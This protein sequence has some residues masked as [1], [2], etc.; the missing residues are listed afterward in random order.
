[1]KMTR[2]FFYSLLLTIVSFVYADDAKIPAIA[3]PQ[4]AAQLVATETASSEENAEAAIETQ[5]MTEAAKRGERLHKAKCMGC[6]MILANSDPA[7]LQYLRDNRKIKSDSG[8]KT[9]VVRCVKA[10][11]FQWDEDKEIADIIA[12]L[13]EKFYQFETQTSK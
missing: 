5:E 6:H 11:G 2:W 9:Q 3:Q 4:A 12:Y 1:M 7:Q 10:F 8:L 13:N